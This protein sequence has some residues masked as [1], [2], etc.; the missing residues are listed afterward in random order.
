MI[1]PTSLFAHRWRHVMTCSHI[2]CTFPR[3]TSPEIDRFNKFQNAPVIHIPQ[4]SIQN[5]D[6]LISV[7]NGTLWELQL[8]HSGICELGLFARWCVLLWID[9]HDDVSI[10]SVT[11]F[12]WWEPTDHPWIAV[13]EAS[14]AEL[15][16][17]FYD[18][19]RT[20]QR[21]RKQSRCRWYETPWCSLWRHCYIALIRECL[22]TCEAMLKNIAEYKAKQ[23]KTKNILHGLYI[24]L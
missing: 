1:S 21:L 3:G 15:W 23:N 9:H 13:T 22:S 5:R 12:L 24:G 7:L 10:F 14:N 17:F 11:G 2:D 8:V 16:W 20:W 19:H 18:V 6:A 4:C